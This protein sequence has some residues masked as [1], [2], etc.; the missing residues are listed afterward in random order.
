MLR[1]VRHRKVVRDILDIYVHIGGD[2]IDAAVRFVRAVNGD[3]SRLSQ[4]PNIGALRE[5]DNPRLREVRS[6][7]VTGF[8]N[9]LIFYRVTESEVQAL[10]VIH[11]ARNI[12]VV[13]DE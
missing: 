1:I 2:S 8:R 6:L 11:G 12:D 4:M 10:R 5:S 13:F 3:L 9:Y 7:P